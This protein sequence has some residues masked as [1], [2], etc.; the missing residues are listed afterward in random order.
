MGIIDR[1][2]ASFNARVIQPN[3]QKHFEKTEYGKKL[4]SYKGNCISSIA[5][6]QISFPS[7]VAEN[8]SFIFALFTIDFIPNIAS[9]NFFQFFI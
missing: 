5:K 2:K 8:I 9:S 1:A 4:T 6:R 7:S 3:M